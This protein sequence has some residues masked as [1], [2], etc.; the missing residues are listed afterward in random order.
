MQVRHHCTRSRAKD[1][2]LASSFHRPLRARKAMTAWKMVMHQGLPIASA[3]DHLKTTP[4]RVEYMLL[5]LARRRA[6]RLAG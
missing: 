6:T 3:A 2:Q 5:A 4:Q 1:S